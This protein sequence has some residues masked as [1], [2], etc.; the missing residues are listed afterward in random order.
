M[1]DYLNFCLYNRKKASKMAFFKGGSFCVVNWEVGLRHVSELSYERSVICACES[2]RRDQTFSE[3]L[4]SYSESYPLGHTSCSIRAVFSRQT[5]AFAACVAW[6]QH[7]VAN[8]SIRSCYISSAIK[9]QEFCSFSLFL[10]KWNCNW[11]HLPFFP[12]CYKYSII[13]Q[14]WK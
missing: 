6:C 14:V 5:G 9:T 8:A 7:D 4:E 1:L 2:K 3:A 12:D 13:P 11:I 10:N